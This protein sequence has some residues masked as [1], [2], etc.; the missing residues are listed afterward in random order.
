MKTANPTKSLLRRLDRTLTA[1]VNEKV[2][3]A[4]F[5]EAMERAAEDANFEAEAEKAIERAVENYNFDEAI[6]DAIRDFDFKES[7]DRI[8]FDH[9]AEKAVEKALDEIDLDEKVEEAVGR[10]L[11]AKLPAALEKALFALLERP[12]VAERLVKAL[13]DKAAS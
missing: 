11:D 1:I 5:T 12:D 2:K 10:V 6:D 9:E 4:D 3:E 13:F 8:D 7:L